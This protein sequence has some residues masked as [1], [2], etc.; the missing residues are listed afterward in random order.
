VQ[1]KPGA[2]SCE[3]SRL[4]RNPLPLGSGTTQLIF[5]A[6]NTNEG[7]CWLLTSAIS[8]ISLDHRRFFSKVS[9][10]LSQRRRLPPRF[11]RAVAWHR[12]L[13]RKPPEPFV[14][15]HSAGTEISRTMT[16][17]GNSLVSRVLSR[18][19]TRADFIQPPEYRCR[20]ETELFSWPDCRCVATN[21]TRVQSSASFGTR[22]LRRLDPLPS[23]HFHDRRSVLL[24]PVHLVLGCPPD[25]RCVDRPIQYWGTVKLDRSRPVGL[26]PLPWVNPSNRCCWEGDG[27]SCKRQGTITHG[28]VP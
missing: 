23:V 13:P 28:L 22:T 18:L 10:F 5:R 25:A 19:E 24:L 12:C 14:V 11:S 9:C 8:N 20:Q 15:N 6:R 16:R 7:S 2:A 1:R 17:H 4:D 21:R 26:R 27:P 3:R